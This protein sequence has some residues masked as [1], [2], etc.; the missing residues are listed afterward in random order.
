MSKDIA[1]KNLT[2]DRFISGIHS[3]GWYT[4]TEQYI[5]HVQVEALYALE[6]DIYLWLIITNLI[7]SCCLV[8][9]HR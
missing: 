8:M 2:V 3:T 4:Y 6:M 9:G 7:S 1:Q 5:L